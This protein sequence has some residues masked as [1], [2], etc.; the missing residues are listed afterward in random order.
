MRL[1]DPE[2]MGIDTTIMILYRLE[3]EIFCKLDFHGGH[4]SSPEQNGT[5]HGE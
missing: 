3:L 4:I 5:T 1:F 2:N